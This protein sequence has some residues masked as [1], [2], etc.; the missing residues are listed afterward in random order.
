M[1]KGDR[2]HD[3][4]WGPALDRFLALGHGESFT[5]EGDERFGNRLRTI[6][7]VSTC[8]CMFQATV[9]RAGTEWRVTKVGRWL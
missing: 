9:K 4:K 1:R 3:S 2:N 5:L 8:T 6:L 7:H